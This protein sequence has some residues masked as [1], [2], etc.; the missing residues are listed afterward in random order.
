MNLIQNEGVGI[1][2]SE[3]IDILSSLP[4]AYLLLVTSTLI[5]IVVRFL[6]RQPP[7]S[8]LV[9]IA[10]IQRLPISFETIPQSGFPQL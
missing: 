4:K 7:T 5:Y 1:A 6:E 9:Y 8:L 10:R 2:S 3:P